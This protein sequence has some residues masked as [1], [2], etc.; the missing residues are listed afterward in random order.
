M[1][2]IC[3][4]QLQHVVMSQLILSWSF[5]QPRWASSSQLTRAF[6]TRAQNVPLVWAVLAW[7]IVSSFIVISDFL[8]HFLESRS[9]LRDPFFLS[10]ITGF[11]YSIYFAIGTYCSL[12]SYLSVVLLLVFAARWVSRA[13]TLCMAG[14][15]S[16]PGIVL[17]AYFTLL[18]AASERVRIPK[19][20]Q[21]YLSTWYTVVLI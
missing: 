3:L 4:P 10:Y 1:V 6:W 16:P 8:C 12:E 11:L 7:S 21:S 2:S 14:K 5:A 17:G 9:L 18:W 13:W 15:H 20:S 19:F